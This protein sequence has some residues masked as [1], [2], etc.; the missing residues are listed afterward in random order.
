M[1]KRIL[2]KYPNITPKAFLVD[3][4]FIGYRPNGQAEQR[5]LGVANQLE[6]HGLKFETSSRAD[7]VFRKRADADWHIK[8]F[9]MW[10][11]LVEL[12][13]DR[14]LFGVESGV[15]SV[16]KRFNKKTSSKENASAIRS[17]SLLGVPPRYTYITFDPLMSVEDLLQTHDYQ[18][19]TDLLLKHSPELQASEIYEIA[20]SDELAARF[21]SGAPLYSDISYQLVSMECLKDA[22]YTEEVRKAGLLREFNTNMGRFN[23]SYDDELIGLFSRCTQRWIDRNFS[24]DY[25]LKS[26]EKYSSKSVRMDIRNMRSILKEYAFSLL[27][28]MLLLNK[29]RPDDRHLDRIDPS[30]KTNWLQ[31]VIDDFETCNSEERQ[32]IIYMMMDIHFEK[33]KS[34][35]EIHLKDLERVL[36]LPDVNRIRNKMNYWGQ[37]KGWELIN[38]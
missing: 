32:L 20:L 38:N 18:A 24:L 22:P 35:L 36:E 27:T 3:E 13:L 37:S 30:F 5:V 10:K 9:E 21:S 26:I 2:R 14:C 1:F 12:G 16:L 23:C 11:Q 19:R 33:L 15:D 6:S 17:L 7:Q 28:K 29:Q 8:R 31:S 34:A 4:E 25:L